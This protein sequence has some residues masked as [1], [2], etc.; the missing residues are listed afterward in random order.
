MNF[1]SSYNYHKLFWGGIVIFE[2]EFEK[3]LHAQRLSAK[4]ARLE[5][6][7]KNLVGEKK[8]LEVV[9]WPVLKSF[10]G[11]ILEHEIVSTTGVKIYID[12]FYE[13]LELGLE[14]EGFVV[15]AEGI[16]RDRFTFERMRIRTMLMYGYKYVPFTWDELEKRPEAC[17]RF[18]YELLGRFSSSS[19]KALEEL[20][21][22]EREVLRYALRLNRPLLLKDA[23]Y[24]LQWG[25]RASRR[26][27]IKLLE[28][29]MIRPLV[30]NK[31]RCHAYVLEEKVHQY[32]L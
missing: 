26:V 7:Q 1:R 31:E 11:I 18:M 23:C 19:G 28:N 8:L 14:S 16:T 2:Q 20:T 27:L 9:V 10:D 3:L 32:M 30:P 29:K 22:S 6:L 5:Q 25:P 21:V 12:V 4:D 17:R 13:P 24:C 15:H